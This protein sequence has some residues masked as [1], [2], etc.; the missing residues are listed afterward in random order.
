MKFVCDNCK[1]KY[2]IRG[3]Q[4]RRQDR[5][6]E[7]PQVRL[8][9][10]GVP[11][12]DQIADG[13]SIDLPSHDVEAAASLAA[14]VPHAPQSGPVAV[15]PARPPVALAEPPAPRSTWG[16]REEESTSIMTAPVRDAVAAA[17]GRPSSAAAPLRAPAAPRP[18]TPAPVRP[19][20]A[21]PTPRPF[22]APRPVGA[23]AASARP[24][25]AG[26]A[27]RAVSRPS[28]ASSAAVQHEHTPHAAPP[29]S[30]HAA[31]LTPAPAAP[32]HEWYV[33][34]G[35]SPIG[36]VRV[37]GDPRA[38]CRKRG[39]RG[40]PRLARR[41]V[42]VASSPHRPRAARGDQSGRDGGGPGPSPSPL[43]AP[44]LAAAAATPA[45]VVAAPAP[46]VAAPAPVVAT[47][48]P[49]Q[50]AGPFVPAASSSVAPVVAVDAVAPPVAAVAPP[51]AAVVSPASAPKAHVDIDPALEASLIP[52]Q[53]GPHPVYALIAAATVSAGSRR[54]CWSPGP[55][56]R[57]RSSWSPAPRPPARP[58]RSPAPPTRARLRSRS[59]S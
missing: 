33:G 23:A 44:V 32:E 58:L 45:P 46:A 26:L 37:C 27:A 18:V 1:A 47:P 39:R 16:D 57:R 3:R 7:V 50:V 38:R 10:Q 12:G 31:P 19:V 14:A 42:G 51:V 48:T 59:A 22:A 5:A 43:A 9:H 6:D 53:R 29:L 25:D 35:G 13:P 54:T 17:T 40:I 4:G 15:P 55:R 52:R 11:D 34:I 30:L 21:A 56:R 20:T 24:N 8:Q 36:P 41:A 49:V 28:S 2:Q